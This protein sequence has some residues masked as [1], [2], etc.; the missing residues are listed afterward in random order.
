M[1]QFA[2]GLLLW[3]FS[4]LHPRPP[5]PPVS[6][7][8]R[9]S[10]KGASDPVR[11]LPQ[12]SSFLPMP[13]ITAAGTVVNLTPRLDPTH[14]HVTTS[15]DWNPN[16]ERAVWTETGRC[17]VNQY[18]C[19]HVGSRPLTLAFLNRCAN[20]RTWASQLPVC[21]ENVQQLTH[22]NY[23]QLSSVRNQ[24]VSVSLYVYTWGVGQGQNQ[25]LLSLT[26]TQ[27]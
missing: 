4:H 1:Y 15:W 23:G 26:H 20:C 17:A 3:Q 6:I 10:G 22:T 11:S 16:I 9:H 14:S 13:I 12:F 27:S 21:T 24:S 18:L 2:L 7:I 8:R 25:K 5:G 19:S